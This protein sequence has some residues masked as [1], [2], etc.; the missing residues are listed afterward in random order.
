[1]NGFKS[2]M[3]SKDN[4]ATAEFQQHCWR[5]ERFL[6]QLTGDFHFQSM[7]YT[8]N[9]AGNLLCVYSETFIIDS[10]RIPDIVIHFHDVL[11]YWEPY[12]IQRHLIL[13]IRVRPDFVKWFGQLDHSM[14]S[15]IFSLNALF[16]WKDC[17]KKFKIPSRDFK[18]KLKLLPFA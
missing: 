14:M 12:T 8:W 3:I 10:T 15:S 1:M 4:V 16:V 13:Q 6:L 18:F 7:Y 9:W 5:K 2:N 11:A 17:Q